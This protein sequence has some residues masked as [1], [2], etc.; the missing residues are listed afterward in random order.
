MLG[1]AI[2]YARAL[3]IDK[4]MLD[5]YSDNLALVK[6]IEARGGRFVESKIY[7]DGTLMKVSWIDVQTDNGIGKK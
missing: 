6:T 3:G 4:L 7:P 1:L 2:E 5:C